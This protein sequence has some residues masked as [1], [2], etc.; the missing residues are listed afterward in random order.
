MLSQIQEKIQ[1]NIVRLIAPSF[2]ERRNE[3]ERIANTDALTGLANRRA[4]DLASGR[5]RRGGAAFI[6][7]DLNN[8]GLVNKQRG[9]AAGDALLQYYADVLA[10]VAFN[11][12]ARVFRLGGDEFVIIC[13]HRF[14]L[15]I[16]DAVERRAMT[17]KFDDFTVSISGEV[18]CSV[19]DCDK[20][21]SARK[22]ERKGAAGK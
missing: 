6:L 12:K 21:L 20:R 8:F 22:A 4:F 11:F 14:A 10:N 1:E 16:R 19:E 3:F 5:A 13:P 18:G 17:R 9:H 7:F 15:N 2:I